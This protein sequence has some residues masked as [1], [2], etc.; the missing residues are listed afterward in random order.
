MTK[1][2]NLTLIFPVSLLRNRSIMCLDQY[3]IL[4]M[5]SI[6]VYMFHNLIY[7]GEDEE[8]GVEQDNEFDDDED[9]VSKSFYIG[10]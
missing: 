3:F 2:E 4:A 9:A 6:G 1:K 8:V 5:R 7:T 10:I